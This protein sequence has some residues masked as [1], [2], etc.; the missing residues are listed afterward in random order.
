MRTQYYIHVRVHYSGGVAKSA[1]A[2]V[3][4]LSAWGDFNLGCA[5]RT[6]LKNDWEFAFVEPVEGFVD[7]YYM[8]EPKFREWY[9]ELC[10]DAKRLRALNKARKHGIPA[11]SS[12]EL[13]VVR[14]GDFI[15]SKETYLRVPEELVPVSVD[16]LAQ[17][18]I[19]RILEQ[20][21]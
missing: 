19:G 17:N 9:N 14:D 16:E 8:G 7:E 10:A 2:E 18:K 5:L 15:D 13:Y 4:C 21:K 6:H 20:C 11:G 3:Y 1:D 12:A